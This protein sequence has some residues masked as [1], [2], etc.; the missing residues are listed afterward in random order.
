[1]RQLAGIIAAIA[2][3]TAC[4]AQ[5]DRD[6]APSISAEAE[7]SESVQSTSQ[8]PKPPIL[9]P[10]TIDATQPEK[11]AEAVAIASVTWDTTNQDSE[12]DSM[13]RVAALLTPELAAQYQPVGGNPAT[14]PTWAA[15]RNAQAYNVPEVFT[16]ED[17]HVKPADTEAT[18]L[19]IYEASW[20]WY[21]AG[22]QVIPDPRKRMLYLT[23]VRQSDGRWLVSTF[24]VIDLN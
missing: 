15:A 19:R 14:E 18:L 21:G 1:M 6:S 11:V 7:S 16:A 24:D 20:T 17:T 2:L 3:L 22:G 10:T 9:E 5:S 12:Y 13:L 23:L 4:S 8:P